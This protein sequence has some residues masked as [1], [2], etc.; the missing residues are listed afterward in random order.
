MEGMVRAGEAELLVLPIVR[1]AIP[2]RGKAFHLTYQLVLCVSC[3]FISQQV[4]EIIIVSPPWH[5][6]SYV[7]NNSDGDEDT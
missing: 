3:L 1:V 7:G 4:G 2:V 5:G 6:T